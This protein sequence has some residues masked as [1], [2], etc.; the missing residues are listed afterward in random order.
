MSPVNEVPVRR[1]SPRRLL[2]A[3]ACPLLL[4]SVL[5]LPAPGHADEESGAFY[6]SKQPYKVPTEAVLASYSDPPAD[7][8]VTYTESVARHGSRGLSSY[9]YDALLMLMAET[10]DAEGG[11]ISEE[12]RDEFIANLEALTAA[13]VENGYGMLTGQG[14]TQ[15][16]GLGERAYTRNEPLFLE[17]EAKGRTIELE[18]SGEARA[19]ESGE[20]W[21]AGLVEASGGALS[22]NLTDMVSSPETLYFHK[23]ENP[24]GT[25]KAEGS[26]AWEIATGYEDYIDSQTDGGTLEAAMDYIEELPRSQEVAEDLLSTVFTQ[27]FIAS[28]GADEAHTWYNTVDGTESGGLN[29]APGA[30]P[31]VD[32]DA[33]GEAG[34]SIES[35]VDAAMDLYNLYIISADMEE[36]NVAPHVFDFDQYFAGH[37]ED[38]EWFAYLLDAEDFYEKGPSLAGHDETFSIAEPL[39]EDFLD[40]IADGTAEGGPAATFRFAHAETIIPFAALLGLPGSTQQ[41]PAVAEPT[42]DADVYSYANNEW[43]GEDV[44]MMAANIQW[45]IATRE[46]VDPGTGEAWTPLVRMLYNEIEIPFNSSCTPVAEGSTWF[47]ATDLASCLTGV[48]SAE[49]PLLDEGA[50]DTPTATPTAL[51]S[52]GATPVATASATATSDVATAAPSTAAPTSASTAT[53]ATAVAVSAASTPSGSLARTGAPGLA[54]MLTALALTAG[55]ASGLL[56]MRRRARQDR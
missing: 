7:Y 48:D 54:L 47:K 52:A 10:A 25:E 35:A 22:D 12:A 20:S 15:H 9:K 6:S 3:A 1:P 19:T 11:F 40:S 26:A 42:S 37:E 28:I 29:C 23:V 55:G 5:A 36:E 21:A 53:A 17:A 50:T 32:A 41:A 33:C 2:A 27:E 45:D 39:L 13:N 14:A 8:S 46:G 43:R 56:T 18:S 4:V 49:S 30:D 51:S 24:D 34:K 16:E 31:A 38:A 44:T